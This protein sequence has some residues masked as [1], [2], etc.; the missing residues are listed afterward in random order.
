MKINIKNARRLESAL[1]DQIIRL[2]NIMMQKSKSFSTA[3]DATYHTK[4]N[5]TT[6]L[7]K[8]KE[9]TSIRSDIRDHIGSFNEQNGINKITALIA[10]STQ[11]LD[12]YNRLCNLEEPSRNRNYSTNEISYSA[13][14]DEETREGYYVI[15]LKLTREIQR[16]K[17]KCQGINASGT[18]EL[19]AE[20]ES[21]L[22]VSGLLD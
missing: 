21:F 6:I 22:K 9:I 17:D 1:D 5:V 12:I 3:K 11:E 18:I 19:S 10:R 7:V 16:L 13:G 8:L 14:L 2:T 4:A 20:Q 15:T